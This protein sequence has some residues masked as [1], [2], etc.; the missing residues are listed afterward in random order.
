[1]TTEAQLEA[2]STAHDAAV[3]ADLRVS[4]GDLSAEAVR[5]LVRSESVLFDA[6][7]VCGMSYDEPCAREWAASRIA[8]WLTGAPFR[9]VAAIFAQAS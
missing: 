7:M 3:R 8:A 4:G 6:A 9:S 5:A 1:M 2:L